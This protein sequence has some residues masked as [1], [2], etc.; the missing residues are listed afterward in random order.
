MDFATANIVFPGVAALILFRRSFVPGSHRT[1]FHRSAVTAF[2]L[3]L[4]FVVGCKQSPPAVID[5]AKTPWLDPKTQMESLKDQD[6][7]IRGLGAFNLGNIG[8]RA[9]DAIPELERLAKND[10]NEKVRENAAK[11]VEKIR[12]ATGNNNQ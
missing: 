6:F 11:A 3:A 4:A 10:S 9:A 7:R 8:A 2:L 1:R 5:P 12:A